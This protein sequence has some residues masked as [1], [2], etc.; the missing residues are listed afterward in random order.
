MLLKIRMN[1]NFFVGILIKRKILM[2][3]LCILYIIF[4]QVEKI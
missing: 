3:S 2:G 4:M 1:I